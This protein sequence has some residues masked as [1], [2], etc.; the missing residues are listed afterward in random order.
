MRDTRG[1]EFGQMI[2]VLRWSPVNNS[3]DNSRTWWP[4]KEGERG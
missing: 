1:S 3:I 2:E 4:Q